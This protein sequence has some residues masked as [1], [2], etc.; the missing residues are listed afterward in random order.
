MTE[1]QSAPKDL[2]LQAALAH[3]P[4]DGW[5]AETFAAAI[6]DSGVEKT[7]AQSVCPRG[8]VDLAILYHEQGDA[9]MLAK[10]AEA[11]L[12]GMKF[13]ERVA[14]AVQFRLEA[15]DDKELVR[16]GTTL[17]ALPMYAADGAK[18]IWGTADAIWNALGDTSDDVNW[19]SKRA[20]LS[21]VYSAT[22]LYWLGDDS[23]GHA[24]TWAFLDRRIENVMQIEKLKAQVKD[25]PLLSK[26]VAGPTW[27]MSHVKAPQRAPQS[28][29][30]GRWDRS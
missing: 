24:D 8:A 16:R 17:F 11:D 2:L 14:A 25:S 1:P 10:L 20:T 12:E 21:G 4:F 22:I 26:L 15:I 5:S 28:G 29:L 3:V 13:R 18:A 6:S 9:Q 7:V 23:D 30:P 19:Y 27:L